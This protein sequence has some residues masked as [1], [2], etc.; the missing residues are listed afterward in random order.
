MIKQTKTR[1][2]GQNLG[3]SLG[4]P[5]PATGIAQGHHGHVDAMLGQGGHLPYNRPQAPVM[6][7]A[8][9]GAF[10]QE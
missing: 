4:V 8:Q 9:H 7:A 1:M 3:A 5:D 2:A 10:A 6:Y